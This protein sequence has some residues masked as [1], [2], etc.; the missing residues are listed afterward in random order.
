[1]N[2]TTAFASCGCYTGFAGYNFDSALPKTNAE[3]TESAP[4]IRAM[5]YSTPRSIA[6]HSHRSPAALI[7]CGPLSDDDLDTAK[8]R[9]SAS[10]YYRFS[11]FTRKAGAPRGAE[12]RD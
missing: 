5:V 4:R 3:L 6:T 10:R 9:G 1:M 12:A 2:A 7:H 11:S 8:V